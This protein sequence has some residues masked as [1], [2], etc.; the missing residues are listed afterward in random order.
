M[1]FMREKAIELISPPYYDNSRYKYINT[2]MN[3]EAQKD[4]FV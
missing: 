4:F 3:L 1:F 2:K